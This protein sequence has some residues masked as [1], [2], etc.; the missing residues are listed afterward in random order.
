MQCTGSNPNKSDSLCKVTI[1]SSFF[2]LSMHS[3]LR[4]RCF[5]YVSLRNSHS[6]NFFPVVSDFHWEDVWDHMPH[7]EGVTTV[8]ITKV[9]P[10]ENMRMFCFLKTF[11]VYSFLEIEY[12]HCCFETSNLTGDNGRG[13]M[14]SRPTLSL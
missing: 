13:F 12:V 6:N 1:L 11:T 9:H 3:Q 2:K 5:F 8:L 10:Y 4:G 7:G 14:S